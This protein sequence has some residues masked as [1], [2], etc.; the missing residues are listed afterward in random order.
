V[1]GR[2]ADNPMVALNQTIALAMVEGPAAGLQRL[3]A[4]AADP[5]LR[6]HYR[7]DA[8]RAHL[9]E[10]AGDTEGAVACYTRAADRTASLPE[11][12]YLLDR[13]LRLRAGV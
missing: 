2:I 9:L 10:R 7:I 1:L 3:E 12:N 11:R 8:V 6:D 13:A 5:R 4:L